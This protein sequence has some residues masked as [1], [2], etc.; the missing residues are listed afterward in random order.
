MLFRSIRNMPEAI[1]HFTLINPMRYFMEIVRGIFL[2]GSGIDSLWPN[3]LA[4]AV[5][6]LTVLISAVM[7]FHKQLD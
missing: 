6:G 2:K 7:R 4:L 3:F 5:L 1:Q